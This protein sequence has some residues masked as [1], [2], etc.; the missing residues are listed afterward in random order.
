MAWNMLQTR[1][2]LWAY[3][4]VVVML[5][6]SVLLDQRDVLFPEIAGMAMGVIVFR[7]P[8]WIKN[9]LHLW[10]S[11]T[12][13]A[14]IGTSLNYAS[15][16][17]LIKLWIGLAIIVILMHLFRVQFGPTIPAALLPIFI[18]LH[19]YVF[20]LSTAV[21]S[22]VIMWAAYAVRTPEKASKDPVKFR[23]V[24]DTVIITLLLMLWM[25]IVAAT[26][27]EALIV[28]PVFALIF[29]VFHS[30][31][32]W[33][34]IPPR[35]AVLTITAL[36]SVG[37]YRL[38]ADSIITVGVI[39]VFITLLICIACKTPV[40]VAFGVSLMPLIYPAWGSWWFPAGVFVTTGAL[41]CISAAN[42]RIRH[43]R[44]AALNE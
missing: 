7:V 17:P 15:L 33:K 26:G 12:L 23:N 3:L 41:M 40:P 42:R 27:F 2:F 19:D 16:A 24:A 44:A 9:P 31:F 18:G 1:R 30:N 32:T 5:A 36:L 8:H 13:G 43:S 6:G 25:G 39:N 4:L 22:F 37:V 34:L 21:F 20:A 11:P 29:E 38:F 28:P 10:L 35:L 14:F